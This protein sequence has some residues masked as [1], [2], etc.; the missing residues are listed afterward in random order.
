MKDD[1]IIKEVFEKS[2]GNAQYCSPKIQ[3]ELVV[4]CGQLIAENIFDQVKS[5]RFFTILADE[6]TNIPRQEQMAAGLR[7]LDSKTFQ[8]RVAFTEFVAVEDLRSESLGQFILIILE[9]LGRI[10]PSFVV[11]EP[12][13]DVKELIKLYA[14]DLINSESARKAELQVKYEGRA[15]WLKVAPCLF[16]KT[17]VQSLAEFERGIF[18]DDHAL[19]A[20]FLCNSHFYSMC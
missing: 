6:T 16:P 14:S 2:A 3:N 15:K 13:G 7:F 20:H 19:L 8:I 5:A 11:K 1:P 10:L 4:I 9:D 18:P 12:I 17:A